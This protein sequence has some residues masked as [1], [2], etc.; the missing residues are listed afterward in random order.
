MLLKRVLPKNNY[1]VRYK[2]TGM[3]WQECEDKSVKVI[4]I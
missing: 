1:T 4:L 2:Y 3:E